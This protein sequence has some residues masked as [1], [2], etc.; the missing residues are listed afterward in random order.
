MLQLE[1]RSAAR[2]QAWNEIKRQW[3][4]PF[5]ILDGSDALPPKRSYTTSKARLGDSSLQ[6]KHRPTGSRAKGRVK[7]YPNVFPDSPKDTLEAHRDTNRASSA[8]IQTSDHVKSQKSGVWRPELEPEGALEYR[9]RVE[10]LQKRAAEGDPQRLDSN[11]ASQYAAKR[12]EIMYQG[13]SQ[14]P[15]KEWE[16]PEWSVPDHI[17]RPWLEYLVQPKIHT[18]YVYDY[19]T[20]EI[21]A[22]EKY[23]E[24]TAAE[25]AA[26]EQAFKDTRKVISS[27]DPDVKITVIG[28]RGTGL[29][30]PLSDID[31]N[32]EFSEP[33][34]SKK[35]GK[36][37]PSAGRPE[38]RKEVV[39]LLRTVTKTLRKK[40]GPKPW[41]YQLAT[42][43]AKVPIV[44]AR[45]SQTKLEIQVQSTTD[46]HASMEIVKAYMNEFPTLRPLF[47][48][49]RQVLK[50][51][52][53]GEARGHGIGSYPLIMM[54]VAT[55]KFSGLR[56][57]PR[58][59][60]RQLLYFLD[61]YA[62]ID[63]RMT[64]ISIEPPE[65]FSKHHMYNSIAS[66][67]GSANIQDSLSP[68]QVSSPTQN[69]A[70]SVNPSSGRTYIR[71]GQSE[72][73]LPDVSPRPSQ[74]FQRPRRPRCSHQA[75]SGHI[76]HPETQ[77]EDRD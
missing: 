70:A 3:R 10:T 16:L 18:Q 47:L 64:G 14:L 13:I 23:M 74:F 75:R 9:K 25:K 61:F 30:M 5:A 66:S 65:L 72:S 73:A 68:G 48:V 33:L 7:Q 6:S 15:K 28:S 17:R 76:L 56:F 41:F 58:D 24:S 29:A 2:T 45:H 53:L 71:R 27:I 19:L 42:I 37:R 31:L 26:V 49:L 20:E 34:F 59:A 67:P 60:G 21:F 4:L 69:G 57:D 32:I 38:A 50:M 46:C 44:H 51:R 12:V 77:G 55:L 62:N 11:R 36:R 1:V 35:P 40:G 22:F 63:L 8:R 39:E 54:I 43:E 52:G